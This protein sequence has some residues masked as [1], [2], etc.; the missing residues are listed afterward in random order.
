MIDVWVSEYLL[1]NGRE[2]LCCLLLCLGKWFALSGSRE[3][4]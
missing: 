4:V 1:G 2:S 3:H